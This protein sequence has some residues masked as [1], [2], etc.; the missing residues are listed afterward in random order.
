VSFFFLIGPLLLWHEF[1]SYINRNNSLN[2]GQKT[3][4]GCVCIF[5]NHIY[6]FINNMS[7]YCRALLILGNNYNT[8]L[9][10]KNVYIPPNHEK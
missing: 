1:D 6:N 8:Q 4:A 3:N 10:Q 9:N 2:D 5:N 7:I